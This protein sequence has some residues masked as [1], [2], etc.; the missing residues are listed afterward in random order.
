MKRQA[1]NFHVVVG[2]TRLINLLYFTLLYFTLLYFT[3]LFTTLKNKARNLELRANSQGT[4]EILQR[5]SKSDTYA[6]LS[7]GLSGLNDYFLSKILK[8]EGHL[9]SN[10]RRCSNCC[11]LFSFADS[12]GFLLFSNRFSIHRI[13]FNPFSYEIAVRDSYGAI[14]LDFDFEQGNV[15]WSDVISNTIQRA[16]L[17]N[18]SNVTVVVENG[19]NTSEGIALDW[20]NRK[21]YWTDGTANKIEVSDLDGKERLPLVTSDLENPRAIVVHPFAG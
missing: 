9:F 3:L 15:Y 10:Y 8:V 14:G 1:E 19:L 5:K 2:M 17:V 21:L 4:R 16:P 20:I 7:S 18:S 12:E 13:N 6:R 11:A